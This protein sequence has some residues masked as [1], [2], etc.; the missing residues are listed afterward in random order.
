MKRTSISAAVVERLNAV[1]DLVWLQEFS[2]HELDLVS[3]GLSKKAAALCTTD[4]F[5]KN[6]YAARINIRLDRMPAFRKRLTEALLV[7]VFAQSFELLND[8][9]KVITW[10]LNN[11]GT[12]PWQPVLHRR[13]PEERLEDS[14]N[15]TGYPAICPELWNTFKYLRLR[16]NHYAHIAQVVSS[17]FTGFLGAQG[18]QLNQFW[19]DPSRM[20]PASPG[21]FTSQVIFTPTVGEISAMLRV[22]LLWILHFDPLIVARLNQTKLLSE[23]AKN[24][25]QAAGGKKYKKNDATVKNLA[26]AIRADFRQETGG[27]PSIAV[28]EELIWR[29]RE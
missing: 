9:I 10:L 25:W 27:S 22:H 28:I 21:D 26:R 16:R 1:N 19:R 29:F 23:F 20:G 11:H 15:A 8:Y 6:P 13:A 24:L 2:L 7:T 5:G 17:G 4:L 18:A 12:S 14:W 3:A